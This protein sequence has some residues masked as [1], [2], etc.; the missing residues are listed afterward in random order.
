MKT[1]K[2]LN[3]KIWYRAIKSIYVILFV[4]ITLW[5]IYWIIIYGPESD[6]LQISIILLI[7]EIFKRAFYYIVLWNLFPPKN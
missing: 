1:I 3:E 2:E 7:L 5:F 4:S 6:I